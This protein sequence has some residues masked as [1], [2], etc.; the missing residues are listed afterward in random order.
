MPE[1]RVLHNA[2]AFAKNDLFGFIP[3]R[4]LED[5]ILP[6]SR[7]PENVF[8]QLEEEGEVQ[9]VRQL[10]ACAKRGLNTEF[11]TRFPFLD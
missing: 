10:D 11:F 2:I 5:S 8:G 1:P 7:L 3:I 6:A 4:F 9:S